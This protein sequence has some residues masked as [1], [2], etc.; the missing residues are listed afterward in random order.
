MMSN[1]D[2]RQI[3]MIVSI[4]QNYKLDQRWIDVS[5]DSFYFHLLTNLT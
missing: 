5:Y 4:I 3:M 1:D 2:H